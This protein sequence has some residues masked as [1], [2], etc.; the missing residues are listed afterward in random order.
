MKGQ[1]VRG[2]ALCGAIAA[3]EPLDGVDRVYV[4]LGARI[5]FSIFFVEI[6]D[7]LA[8]RIDP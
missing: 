8:K 5:G 6:A 7:G 3:E 2:A 4:F 1:L